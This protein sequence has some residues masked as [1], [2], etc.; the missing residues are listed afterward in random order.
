MSET[1]ATYD[2][3]SGADALV[4]LARRERDWIEGGKAKVEVE[5]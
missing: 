5:E 3:D 4:E 1:P 2:V